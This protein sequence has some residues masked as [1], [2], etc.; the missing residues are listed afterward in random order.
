MPCK[1]ACAACRAEAAA[2]KYSWPEPEAPLQPTQSKAAATAY[3]IA[4][5][6]AVAAGP[7]AATAAGSSDAC[8]AIVEE[9]DTAAHGAEDTLASAGNGPGAICCPLADALRHLLL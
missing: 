9:D 2:F 4:S 6:P 7:A 8:D 5:S 1:I 3:K